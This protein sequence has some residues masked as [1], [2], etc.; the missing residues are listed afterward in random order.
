MTN[1]AGAFFCV[2][3]V[4]WAVCCFPPEARASPY[5]SVDR[6]SALAARTAFLQQADLTDRD[7]LTLEAWLASNDRQLFTNRISS[8]SETG[9]PWYYYIRGFLGEESADGEY[10]GQ[11]V[12]AAA[13]ARSAGAGTLWLLAVEFI[14]NDQ[15]HWAANSL[16]SLERRMFTAGGSSAPF[17]AK[18]LMLMGNAAAGQSAERAEFCYDWAKMFDAN[19]CWWLYKKGGIDFPRN[20]MATTPGFIAEVIGV[21]MNSWRAQAAL[22]SGFYRFFSTTAFI[23]ICAIFL[24][25]AV[26][27]LPSG[28]H[29]VGDALFG[30]AS[31][32]LRTV[33]GVTV[34][35]SVL[36]LGILPGLW[37]IAF[38]VYRFLNPAEK[39]L[40]ALACVVLAIIPLNFYAENF[41]RRGMEPASP[42]VV[43]DRAIRE[44]YSRG[45]H[46]LIEANIQKD[47]N[48]HVS[49]TA[50]AV[51][52]VKKRDF[53]Q[54]A[55]A[56]DKALRLAPSDPMTLMCAGNISFL[57]KDNE[58]AEIFYN[59]LR[60]IQPGNAAAKFNLAQASMD[61]GSFK[62]TDMMAVAA[63]LDPGMI[64][65]FLRENERHFSSDAPPMRS[66]IWPP[67][68]PRYFWGRLFLANP[69]EIFE[70]RGAM[71]YGVP[72]I[73]IFCVSVLLFAAL[74]VMNSTVWCES[75]SKVKK[76]FIC[77]ICGRLICK[78]CR[79]GTMCATCYNVYRNAPNNAAAIHNLQKKHQDA[80]LMRKDISKYALGALVPGAERLYSEEKIFKPAVKVFITS[81]IFA[82][83]YCAFTF[84]TNYPSVAVMNPLP[85]VSALLIYNLAAFVRQSKWLV[86]TLRMRAKMAGK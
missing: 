12:A 9:S 17:L 15:F 4:F 60:K 6:E 13:R 39:K 44:G 34:V 66:I 69:A 67:V 38:A 35:L 73:A 76:Y 23:F 64:S 24:V 42:A 58:N 45:L 21:S 56:L 82:A 75:R 11:A 8:L 86:S 83:Y 43:L 41:L 49:Q 28:V 2:A 80:A 3:A 48:D 54:S 52:A 59:N 70:S 16:N 61:K 50:L 47:P 65:G 19:Q 40:A 5:L 18:L 62:A 1:R 32:R 20:V 63:E 78:K 46:E 68:S 30:G 55:A 77:R 33:S 72:P 25:F 79:K 22:L 53:D 74:P 85:Y 27:Y 81:A 71:P 57:M 36:I 29:P 26:K 10:Y 37:A 14:R 7:F 31:M 51:S 84:R